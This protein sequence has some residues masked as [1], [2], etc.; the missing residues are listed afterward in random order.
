M[1]AAMAMSVPPV[2]GGGP[3]IPPDYRNAPSVTS[4][5]TPRV[6]FPLSGSPAGNS[7]AGRRR[8]GNSAGRSAGPAGTVRYVW[9]HGHDLGLSVAENYRAFADDA[10]GRSP[11]YESLALAVAGDDTV[12]PVLDSLP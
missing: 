8:P 6:G 5:R 1:V 10:P 9:M 12:L 11:V 2:A 7:P 4:R 3:V